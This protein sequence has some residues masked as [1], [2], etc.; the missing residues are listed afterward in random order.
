MKDPDLEFEKIIEKDK[1]HYFVYFKVVFLLILIFLGMG[2]FKVFSENTVLSAKE[3]QDQNS[4]KTISALQNIPNNI[5]GNDFITS[6][7]NEFFSNSI[8]RNIFGVKEQIL[9]I[10]SEEAKLQEKNFVGSFIDNLYDSTILNFL[11]EIISNLPQNQQ[12]RL[13]EKIGN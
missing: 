9:G 13:I 3:L 2:I 6:L 8:V 10:A 1:P 7:Q 5:M 4:S 11:Q 12:E